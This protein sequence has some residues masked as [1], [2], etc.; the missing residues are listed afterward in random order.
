MN[1]L[2]YPKV[3]LHLGGEKI[4][5]GS[6][7]IY[8]HINASTGEIDAQIPLAGKEDVNRAVEASS[9]AFDIWRRW[10]PT[11]R[12]DV[13]LRLANLLER[14]AER[15]G[16]YTTMDNS[17]PVSTTAV[18]GF[19]AKNWIAYYAGFA[20]KIE[21]SVTSS[22]MSDTDFGYTH[23]E[24]YGVVGL[25]VTWNGPVPNLCMKAGAALA[26]GNTIVIKTPE[27]APFSME[28]FM[29]C[30]REAG[31]PDGVITSFPGGPEAGEALVA[32][33][34]VRKISF[35][36]GPVGARKV[37]ETCARYIKPA[38]LEL[39]G[40]SAN[41]V[42]DDANLDFAAQHAALFGSVII[43]GQGCC[44]PTRLLVQDT[45]YDE[46]I[47]RLAAVVRSVK[48]GD[49]WDPKTTMG[50]VLSEVGLQRTLGYIERAQANGEGR[51]IAGGHRVGGELA[52]GFYLEPTI[53]ADVDNGS[54]LGCEEIFG[55]VLTVMKFSTEEEA[56][57]MANDTPY[58]LA[59]YIQ[60]GNLQRVHRMAAELNA[61]GIY[62]NGGSFIDPSSPFGGMGLS[63]FG[64]EGGRVGLDEFLQHKAVRIGS[65]AIV[66]G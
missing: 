60:S 5:S 17:I 11:E 9:V 48:I 4:A 34:K 19:L 36:G 26:A 51:L 62:V 42:F 55:P 52:R 10:K 49:P 22:Y 47:E 1:R 12:R 13:L 58:G 33:P 37:L 7:G 66:F 54:P 27:V 2:P 32:H 21:G 28:V 23:L 57:R 8:Q 6:G 16:Q 40:K 59:A 14:N 41:I 25:I 20:D 56:I 63:G 45:I 39:G 61:G 31:I 50:P 53:F 24:P 46:M 15:M 30:V 38:V 43:S 3:H 29:E 35:T 44:L 18:Q 65:G 64:R